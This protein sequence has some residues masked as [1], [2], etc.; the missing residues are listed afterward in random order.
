MIYFLVL[1]FI[2]VCIGSV[3]FYIKYISK[4]PNYKLVRNGDPDF[5]KGRKLLLDILEKSSTY[6][7]NDEKE[8]NDEIDSQN[9]VNKI[10][11]DI[12]EHKNVDNVIENT[13]TVIESNKM[14]TTPPIVFT[15]TSKKSKNNDRVKKY[16]PTEEIESN[17]EN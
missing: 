6:K 15:R 8:K 5:I 11:D 14:E 4:Q 2:I 16:K 12:I 17:E 7:E 9:Q 3:I 10:D 13:D 1:A